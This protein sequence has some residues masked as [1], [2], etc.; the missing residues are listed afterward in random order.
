MDEQ[1]SRRE[2]V[3]GRELEMPANG[4]PPTQGTPPSQPTYQTKPT[5]SP[6]KGNVRIVGGKLFHVEDDAEGPIPIQYIADHP[7]LGPRGYV[8]AKST[9]PWQA[10]NSPPPR[11]EAQPS[12][13]TYPTK[14]TS[15]RTKGNVRI[16]GGK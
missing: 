16:V 9:H 4:Q 11:K 14:P 2:D 5:Y 15:T 8:V 6:R 13:P 7:D 3:N 1:Q 10:A 12:E